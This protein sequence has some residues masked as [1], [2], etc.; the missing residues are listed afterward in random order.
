MLTTLGLHQLETAAPLRL[1][2]WMAQ[3]RRTRIKDAPE[4]E[5]PE[6]KRL[7]FTSWGLANV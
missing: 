4:E 5:S 2:C 6:A 3:R 7:K 1:L